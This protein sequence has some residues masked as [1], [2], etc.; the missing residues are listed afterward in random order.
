MSQ[1]NIK[2]TDV[3][4]PPIQINDGDINTQSVDI[5][6]FGHIKLEYGELLNEN[7]LHLL[8][9][10]SCPQDPSPS[11]S[12]L[13]CDPYPVGTVLPDL[14]IASVNTLSHPPL[15]QVW[16]NSTN[17]TPYVCI[18]MGDGDCTPPSWMPLASNS[19]YAAN[20]GKIY[21]GQ[22]LPLPVSN[23]GY[24]FT[25]SECVWVLTPSGSNVD[26]QYMVCTASESGLVNHQ[27]AISGTGILV[28]GIANYMII[29][30]KSNTNNGSLT[31]PPNPPPLNLTPT[32]SVTPSITPSAGVSPTPTPTQSVTPTPSV[33]QTMPPTATPSPTPTLTP[34]RTVPAIQGTLLIAP[35]LGFF[36]KFLSDGR[37]GTYGVPPI[38]EPSLDCTD[39]THFNNSV[40]VDSSCMV[41]KRLEAWVVDITGGNGGPYALEWNLSFFYSCYAYNSQLSN[42][43]VP[44]SR[45]PS[46]CTDGINPNI[47]PQSGLNYTG[48]SAGYN[49]TINY[50]TGYLIPA[51]V[52]TGGNVIPEQMA[53]TRAVANRVTYMWHLIQQLARPYSISLNILNGSSVTIRDTSGNSTTYYYPSGSGGNV[54]GTQL[55]SPPGGNYTD[56]YQA[57]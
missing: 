55:T 40:L 35:S 34:S 33:T 25:Y 20:W 47:W 42:P 48:S 2:Y 23:S 50:T 4:V 29:G 21:H 24:E 5:A 18:D 41:Q 22:Q 1:Y 8:E 26:F 46:Q 12:N 9:N 56:S 32:P 19:D 13:L 57:T 3:N 10:F 54:S 15:G 36:N 27:Y 44:A 17:N 37:C 51:G 31:T 28:D 11:P 45:N 49:V 52:T 38:L 30:I 6:L 14:S 53:Y 39:L 7:F 16:F 43:N